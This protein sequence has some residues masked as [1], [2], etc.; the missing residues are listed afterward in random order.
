MPYSVFPPAA[1]YPPVLGEHAYYH[2]KSTATPYMTQSYRLI[3]FSLPV[4]LDTLPPHVAYR[5]IVPR[6]MIAAPHLI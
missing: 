5:G 6:G 1:S 3:N 4:P 2:Q